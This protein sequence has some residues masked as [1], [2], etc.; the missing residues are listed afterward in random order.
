MEL[1]FLLDVKLKE[2]GFAVPCK[3]CVGR[4]RRARRRWRNRRGGRREPDRGAS[5]AGGS[6][7]RQTGSGERRSSRWIRAW[8]R[9]AG[10]SRVPERVGSRRP[11]PRT[12]LGLARESGGSKTGRAGRASEAARFERRR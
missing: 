8:S 4:L 2:E 9:H 7:R 5:P 1:F 11:G 10:R 6:A 12:E 3:W